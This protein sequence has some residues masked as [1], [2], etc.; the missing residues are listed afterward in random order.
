MD[1]YDPNMIVHHIKRC[2]VVV[3]W[4]N[5]RRKIGVSLECVQ[6]A[7]MISRVHCGGRGGGGGSAMSTPEDCHYL[8]INHEYIIGDVQYTGQIP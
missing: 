5:I 2:S 6:H 1:H 4:E 3:H 8:V 7:G